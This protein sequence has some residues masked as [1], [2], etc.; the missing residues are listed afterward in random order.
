M[1]EAM[2]EV[3]MKTSEAGAERQHPISRSVALHL[4]PGVLVLA[5]YVLFGV[6]AAE[7]LG[8]PALFGLVLA[9]AFV[10]IPFE[11]GWLLYLGLRRNGRPSLEGVVLYR[12]QM[13]ARRLLLLG[14]PLLGWA[15][16]VTTTLSWIDAI[17][18]ETLFSW[19][20]ERLLIEHGPG[21]YVAEYPRSVLVVTLLLALVLFGVVA[22]VVE[23]LYFR[24]YLLPRL[25]R[26][27]GWAAPVFNVA[28]FALY[29]LWTPWQAATR[30]ISILP[31]A[32]VVQ[33]TRNIYAY[34]WVPCVLN[35][36]GTLLTLAAV[37]AGIRP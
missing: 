14:L 34:M 31:A 8:C 37:L 33:R 3:G 2:S 16:L 21:S 11:L 7:R 27:G 6:P 5:F 12:E 1:N 10:L 17:V 25:S 22:P 32:Y 36:V 9:G 23:E 28:L 35:T 4:L 29:H 20:P 18:F 15:V 19:V 13:P 26:L 24:G 30:I